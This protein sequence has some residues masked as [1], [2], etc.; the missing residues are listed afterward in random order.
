MS[1]KRDPWIYVQIPAYRDAELGKTLLSL[2]AKAERPARLRTCVV[3]QRSEHDELAR[4]VR[5]LPNLEIV[6]VPYDAS[7]GCNWARSLLQQ[8]WREETFTLVLD[9]H[10]RFL[11]CW[12]TAV[13]AMFQQLR[14]TRAEK[15]LLTAYLPA[16]HPAREPGARKKRPYKIYPYEREDGVLTRLTSYPLPYW[17]T[18]RAPVDA[19]FLSLHFTFTEGAFNVDVPCDPEIYFFGD[20]VVTGLRAYMAGYD[21]FHPH[22][23][24]GWHCYERSSRVGHWDDHADWRIKHKAG[25]EKLRAIYLGAETEPTAAR[26]KR[27]V[28]DYQQHIMVDLV[29]Q[30]T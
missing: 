6:D 19:Q 9:S 8:R 5:E 20:E 17:T 16:Y 25:L 28:S 7:G 26:P 13:V 27:T 2:Y 23:I 24:V 22:R 14:D 4:E 1:R 11:R 21:L 12:D 3:W 10:H 30:G 29:E 15:P 18:L